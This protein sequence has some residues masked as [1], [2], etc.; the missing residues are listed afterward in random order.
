MPDP[1]L[2]LILA[3]LAMNR[4]LDSFSL[5]PSLKL[6]VSLHSPFVDCVKFGLQ[7]KA[8]HVAFVSES[9]C[10]MACLMY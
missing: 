3:H 10:S 4:T 2:M 5:A 1:F 9:R 6:P 7:T 8:H